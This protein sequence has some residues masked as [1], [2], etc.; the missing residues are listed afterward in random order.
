M[1]KVSLYQLEYVVFDFETTGL[2]PHEGD[3]IIE[4]GALKLRGCEPT[5]ETFQTLIH[6]QKPIPKQATSV[7]GIS[8]KDLIG[9]PS[10]REIFPDFI[11][12]IGNKML[13]AHNATFDLEFVKKGLERFPQTSFNNHCIDTLQVSKQ[14]FSYEKGHSLDAIANR[15]GIHTK[16]DDTQN[17][18]RSLGDCH[19]TARIFSE[20]LK[21]LKRRNMATLQDIR[22]CILHPPKISQ[23]HQQESLNL[24]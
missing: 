19:L 10:L 20:F 14:I 7:H 15:F 13:I 2:S 16:I 8:D 3:E 17:R 23:F 9:K 11:R 6:I 18:H 4:I 5:G 24:L 12:F 22:N 21:T 1:A